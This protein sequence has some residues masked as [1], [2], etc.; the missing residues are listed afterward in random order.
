M[1]TTFE[2]FAADRHGRLALFHAE[3]WGWVPKDAPPLHESDAG[4]AAFRALHAAWVRD[5]G[6]RAVF[7]HHDLAAVPE[8]EA[9]HLV[10]FAHTIPVLPGA[11]PIGDHVALFRV[12]PNELR[13][14]VTSDEDAEDPRIL[15]SLA[16]D[17][18]SFG[19][20]SK[21]ALYSFRRWGDN[22]R[23]LRATHEPRFSLSREAIRDFPVVVLDTDF[24][25]CSFVDI[26]TLL[27][28]DQ[29]LL[30]GL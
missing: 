9:P 23:Y 25:N 24:T 11:E 27:S 7:G 17:A 30:R 1:P 10:A 18:D 12:I 26:E 15:G 2:W 13:A 5:V 14:L 19:E 29:L 16:V 28:P 22:P 21:D 4:A 6:P 3:R 20:R 8:S